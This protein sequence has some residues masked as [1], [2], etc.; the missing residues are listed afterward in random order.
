[1]A[2]NTNL[3]IRLTKAD[4]DKVKNM[5]SKAGLSVSEFV[6]RRLGLKGATKKS[7]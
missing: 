1:M 2:K 4:K 7:T 3:L 5:A 6:R